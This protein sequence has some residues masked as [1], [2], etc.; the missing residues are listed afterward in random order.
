MS[1]LPT[2]SHTGGFYRVDSI[3]GTDSMRLTYQQ[4][5]V[6]TKPLNIIYRT[7]IQFETNGFLSRLANYIGKYGNRE[8]TMGERQEAVNR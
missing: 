1:L 5:T 8:R 7:G 4:E 6:L 3:P 2:V